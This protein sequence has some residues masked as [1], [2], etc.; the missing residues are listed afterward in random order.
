MTSSELLLGHVATRAV[1]PGFTGTEEPFS[2]GNNNQFYTAP[3]WR[4]DD[5]Q[6]A[7]Q[8]WNAEGLPSADDLAMSCM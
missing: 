8:N 7:V 5:G 1:L 2:T 3:G 4:G 6:S